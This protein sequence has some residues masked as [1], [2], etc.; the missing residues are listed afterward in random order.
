MLIKYRFASG[1]ASVKDS[2][3]SLRDVS[4]LARQSLPQG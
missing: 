2:G 1:N 3:C 4:C